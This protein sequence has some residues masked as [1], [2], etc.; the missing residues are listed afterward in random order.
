[1]NLWF[2]PFVATGERVS[3]APGMG[4]AETLQHYWAFY[5]LTSLGWDAWAATGNVLLIFAI[6]RPTLRT[7]SRSRDRFAVSFR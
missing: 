4:L 3:W 1:M 7:L 2:W 6:G 5:V